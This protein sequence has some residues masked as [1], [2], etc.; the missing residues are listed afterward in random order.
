MQPKPTDKQYLLFSAC[1]NQILD[2]N[3]SMFNKGQI[4]GLYL[5]F[6]L[7]AIKSSRGRNYLDL[8]I[9]YGHLLIGIQIAYTDGFSSVFCNLDSMPGGGIVP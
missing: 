5:K 1:L 6:S 8:P 9:G 2:N 4:S 7:H 3:H